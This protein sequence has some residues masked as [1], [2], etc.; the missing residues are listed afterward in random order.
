[1]LNFKSK[2]EK[3]EVIYSFSKSKLLGTKFNYRIW[4]N[5]YTKKKSN[6]EKFIDRQHGTRL[7][8]TT[9][10][11]NA[12]ITEFTKLAEANPTKSGTWVAEELAKDQ[13]YLY[14]SKQAN[15][16]AEIYSKR[17]GEK[18]T[19]RLVN[20]FKFGQMETAL[21]DFFSE[22]NAAYDSLKTLSDADLKTFIKNQ[23]S[24]DDK[25]KDKPASHTEIV[26]FVISQ[27]F[28]GSD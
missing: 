17:T 3:D 7:N 18:F 21:D 12:F 14:T 9:L 28:Y 2:G 19:Q 1:M 8:T 4:Y 15:K 25:F 20:K 24:F 11:H 16:R 23:E 6:T 26:N 13:I 10:S 22:V 27:E 5:E